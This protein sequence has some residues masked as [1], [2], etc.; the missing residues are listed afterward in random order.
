MVPLA[1]RRHYW[2]IP[3]TSLNYRGHAFD[4]AIH[5]AVK[6]PAKATAELPEDTQF[7]SR[8]PLAQWVEQGGKLVRQWNA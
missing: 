3:M 6:S 2:N 4:N 7:F 5:E 8:H 1:R